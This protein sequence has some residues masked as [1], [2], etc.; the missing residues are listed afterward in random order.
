MKQ[1][2]ITGASRG[3]GAATALLM[4]SA[5]SRVW[6]HYR[7]REQAARDIAKSIM[8][9]GG[10]EPVL[11]SFD[12]AQ[13]RDVSAA[14]QSVLNEMGA[15][16][17]LVLNAGISRSG[18]FA[19]TDDAEWDE[20]MNTNVGGFLGVARPTVKA[21]I[22]ERRGRIVLLSSVA[23]L[24][25]NPGQVLYAASKGALTAAARSLALEL[26]PRGITVN[27]VAPGLIE[28]EMLDGAPINELLSMVPLGRVGKPIEVA[29]VIQYLCSDEA[30][31]VTGQV[32]GVNG[33]MWM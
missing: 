31:Y 9:N 19:F 32:I 24:R 12:L 26:A 30:A 13:R 1:V 28:T 14:V 17:A 3:I 27:V 6:L 2:L 29:H 23:A 18:L 15:P 33:G 22:R 21:M 5:G 8:A 7:S 25:G 20:V 10:P 4:G 16:D 11:I